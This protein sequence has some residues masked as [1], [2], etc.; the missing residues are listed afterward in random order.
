MPGQS[1][2]WVPLPGRADRMGF[3]LTSPAPGSHSQAVLVGCTYI[4]LYVS[5][6]LAFGRVVGR[7]LQCSSSFSRSYCLCR[8]CE[9]ASPGCSCHERITWARPREIRVPNR[10][11]HAKSFISCNVIR[12]KKIFQVG[13]LVPIVL[14]PIG[15]VHHD[16]REN[17]KS[18]A[19]TTVSL[20]NNITL[21]G[22]SR[23]VHF[24]FP[25][26]V[27][28]REG[29]LTLSLNNWS[30]IPGWLVAATSLDQPGLAASSL[31]SWFPGLLVTAI[32]LD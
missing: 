13:P 24:V 31:D 20:L 30:W 5:L 27:L 8:Q 2:S 15:V 12:K 17:S 22:V 10:L 23:W 26:T 18:E 11:G 32:S 28:A 6:L 7:L 14:P 16:S 19:K 3:F 29:F 4:V 21:F 9:E 25:Q 1:A